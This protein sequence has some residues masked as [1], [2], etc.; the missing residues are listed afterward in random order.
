MWSQGEN[1]AI[2]RHARFSLILEKDKF[3]S[4]TASS[5]SIEH[6]RLSYD[7]ERRREIAA[8]RMNNAFHLLFE[9]D[10]RTCRHPDH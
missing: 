9:A 6:G 10:H 4:L 7:H 5:H 8:V 2:Q 3:I 1:A